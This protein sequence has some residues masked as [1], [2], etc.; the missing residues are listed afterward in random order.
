MNINYHFFAKILEIEKKSN[1]V[2]VCGDLPLKNYFQSK[3]WSTLRSMYHYL[4]QLA[5]WYHAISAAY[6][7]HTKLALLNILLKLYLE[8]IEA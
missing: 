6:F 5:H 4:C 3:V 8:T 7:K 2:S 1:P